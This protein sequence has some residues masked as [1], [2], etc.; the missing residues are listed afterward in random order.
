MDSEGHDGRIARALQTLRRL[1]SHPFALGAARAVRRRLPGDKEYGDPLSTAGTDAPQ[2]IG[3]RLATITADRP[4]AL[5]EVGMSALQV[6]QAVSEASGRGHGHEELAILFT[7]L[8]GFSDWT[9]EAGDTQA[10]ELLRRVGKAGEPCIERHGGRVVK[11][12][13]DGLM[14]VL[15]DASAGVEAALDIQRA[16][17]DISVGGYRPRVRAGVHVGRPRKLGHDYFGV[18]VNVAA[19]IAAAAG[20]DEVLISE[21][22]REQLAGD[23]VA[24]RRRWMFTSKG[25]PKGLRVYAA[26]AEG[27]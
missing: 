11:R 6:W 1:D 22:A 15:P 7:D 12:L 20:A 10:L 19:R 13:G 14:A 24:T 5:R 25:T 4:S 9:L 21:A 8:A 16:M 27:S 18:D 17:R 3:Q 26:R 23:G 2:L